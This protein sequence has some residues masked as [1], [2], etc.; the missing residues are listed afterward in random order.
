MMYF[1]GLL[2]ALI[3]LSPGSVMGETSARERLDFLSQFGDARIETAGLIL[4]RASDFMAETED[5]TFE[6]GQRAFAR[7]IRGVTSFSS[8]GAIGPDGFLLFDSFNEKSFPTRLDLSDREYVTQTRIAPPNE[9]FVYPPIVGRQSGHFIIPVALRVPSLDQTPP[10]VVVVFMPAE[11]L[12]PGMQICNFCGLVVVSEG[13]VIASDKI[14]SAMNEDT[15]SSLG[16]DGYYGVERHTIRHVDV[17]FHWKRS[18]V[19][20]LVYVYYEGRPV[21][22]PL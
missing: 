4:R 7:M 1:R 15:I 2:L 9:P 3:L 14:L 20:N 6:D 16:L 5:P 10:T 22:N 21:R 18:S 17:E 8:L 19:T 11:N 12:L 13:R